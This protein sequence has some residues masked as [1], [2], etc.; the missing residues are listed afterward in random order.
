[1]RTVSCK[2]RSLSYLIVVVRLFKGSVDNNASNAD[3][4]IEFRRPLLTNTAFLNDK[5]MFTAAFENVNK[6]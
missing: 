5:Q 2:G 6:V 3:E 1:M 4:D